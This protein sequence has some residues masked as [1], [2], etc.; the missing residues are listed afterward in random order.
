MDSMAKPSKLPPSRHETL[1]L[2]LCKLNFDHH[3]EEG[4]FFPFVSTHP[5]FRSFERYEIP[6]IDLFEEILKDGLLV[7]FVLFFWRESESGTRDLEKEW[8]ARIRLVEG[9]K[10]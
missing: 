7:I 4:T 8:R 5:R 3:R 1:I 6:G 2:A 9:G 10:I